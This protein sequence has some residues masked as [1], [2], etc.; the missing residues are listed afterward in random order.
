MKIIISNANSND[1]NNIVKPEILAICPTAIIE[2]RIET[3]GTSVSYAIAQGDIDLI[4]RATTGLDDA[5]E[6]V[7]GQTAAANGIG[8]VHAHGSNSHVYLANP[9]YIGTICA[10]GAGDDTPTNLDSYGPGLEFFAEA[11]TQS[12]ATGMV[13]GMIAQLMIDH[14]WSFDQARLALRI[15][16]SGYP[17]HIDDGGYGLVDYSVAYALEGLIETDNEKWSLIGLALPMVSVFPEPAAEAFDQADWQQLVW[18]YRGI[19]TLILPTGKA[20]ISFSA[21]KP[22]L[23]FVIKNISCDFQGK[24]PTINFSE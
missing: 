21:K 3:L 1:A 5:R 10:A 22:L 8:I 24:I 15:S 18:L 4:C 2:V 16:A 7:Q 6:T 19:I 23:D 13:T 17:V 20:V 14:S 12:E 9:T 11:A